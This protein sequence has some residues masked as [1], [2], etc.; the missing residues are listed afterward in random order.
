MRKI[1]ISIKN[2]LALVFFL[3]NIKFEEEIKFIKKKML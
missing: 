1:N 3:R 2:I